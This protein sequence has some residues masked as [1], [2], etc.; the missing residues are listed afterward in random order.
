MRNNRISSDDP[1][2]IQLLKEKIAALE[3]LQ[4]KMKSANKFVKKNDRQG[5]FK[6]GFNEKQINELL[7]P[8]FCGRIGFPSFEL[9]NNRQNITSAK[10]RL[11]KLEKQALD[12]TSE[13]EF[14]DLGLKLV[15]NVEDNRLRLYFSEKPAKEIREKLRSWG[16]IWAH[17]L[18]CWQRLRGANADYSAKRVIEFIQK[19]NETVKE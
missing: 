17:T 2:A 19:Y 12:E 5:L 11:A 13:Q 18:N 7:T 6:L 1:N 4:E 15:D 3:A 9:S 8:D 10:K 14:P 16:F